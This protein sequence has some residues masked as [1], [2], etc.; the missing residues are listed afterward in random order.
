M[1][2][3][4]DSWVGAMMLLVVGIV[5]ILINRGDNKPIIVQPAVVA[6]KAEPEPEPEKEKPVCPNPDKCP[7]RRGLL[8]PVHP[9]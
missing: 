5:V 1:R 7:R 2:D 9:K 6:P 8:C 4:T 3:N